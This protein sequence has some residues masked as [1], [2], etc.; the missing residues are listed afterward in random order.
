MIVE[1]TT[2]TS[3]LAICATP[4]PTTIHRY[5]GVYF[6]LAH[7]GESIYIAVARDASRGPDVPYIEYDVRER[8]Y[9]FVDPKKQPFSKAPTVVVIPVIEVI[10]L[11][12]D[13][14]EKIKKVVEKK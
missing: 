11:S 3:L 12:G 1:E 5:K 6:G 2:F 4:I 7:I 10:E 8:T 13:V 14:G 9:W